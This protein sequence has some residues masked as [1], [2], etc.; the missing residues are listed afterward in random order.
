MAKKKAVTKTPR[1]RG[2]ALNVAD[3]VEL[4]D[5]LSNRAHQTAQ[6]KGW[7]RDRVRL[8]QVVDRYGEDVAPFLEVQNKLSLLGLIHSEVSEA[9]N[10]VRNGIESD[11]K[12]PA[13]TGLE[14]E[15]ADVLIRIFDMCGKYQLRLGAAVIAKMAMNETRPDK[16]GGKLA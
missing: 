6:D 2:K 4:F 15:L 14:A 9:L 11:D 1:R 3:I 12:V 5:W 8:Q 16:H 10:A 13:F 7:W